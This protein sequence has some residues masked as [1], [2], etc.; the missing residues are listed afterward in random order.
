MSDYQPE[1]ELM[2]LCKTAH[3]AATPVS[4]ELWTIL[5][6]AEQI[7]RQTDGAFDVTAGPIVRLWRRARKTR[8]LPL[9]E[10]IA[11][12]RALVD[13]RFIKFDAATRSVRL[14]KPGMQL[15]L[16][17][18]AKGFAA[19][20]AQAAL[21]QR[22][23]DRALVAAG[24]DIV[25]SDQPPGADGWRIGITPL[26]NESKSSPTVSLRRRAISTSGDAEQSVEIGGTRYS[27]IVDPRTGLALTERIQVSV[28]APDGTTA[29][30]LAT[31][32]SVLGPE[33]G[34]S[35]VERLPGVGAWFVWKKNDAREERR[36]GGF[37]E[38]IR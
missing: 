38:L 10:R 34:L 29:D 27:H 6:R 35:I 9:P 18:I 37:P 31:G 23:I 36:S 15:D 32:L 21:R 22:G 7:S 20:E 12:A 3:A 13:Y 17:G 24:G 4:A 14:E 5:T 1:S 2:R 16:G 25:V 26:G 28:I 8:E 11:E 30:A 19:E 33:R